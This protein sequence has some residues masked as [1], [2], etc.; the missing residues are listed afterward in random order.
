[1]IPL[2]F[3]IWRH[4]WKRYHFV[5]TV[6]M[7][8]VWKWTLQSMTLKYNIFN[9][10]K[11]SS[12]ITWKWQS[13]DSHQRLRQRLNSNYLLTMPLILSAFCSS[14]RYSIS[15]K[16]VDLHNVISLGLS[17]L[18]FKRNLQTYF[19]KLLWELNEIMPLN[20]IYSNL[21]TQ[22]IFKFLCIQNYY[23]FC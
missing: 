23:V 1:M 12:S 15:Q 20:S 19:I 2:K 5:T 22:T 7:R 16:S 17:F 14:P 3:V 21:D 8:N 10:Q 9:C 4:S 13:W 11:W 6:T 18:F